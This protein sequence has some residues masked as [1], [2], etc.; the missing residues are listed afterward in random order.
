VR[1]EPN[2]GPVTSLFGEPSRAAIL[3]VLW[4]GRAL[5]ASEL[6]RIAGLSPTAASGH[7]SKL[8]N[9]KL[10]IMERQGRHRYYRLASAAVAEIIENLAQLTERP[11][12]LG[13]PKLSPAARSLRYAR[14]CYNHLAGELA[15]EVAQALENRGYLRREDDKRYELGGEEARR[16]F[17]AQGIDFQALRP[18]RYGLA[19]QC[20]DWT[21]RCPHL[22]GPLGTRLFQCWC[23]RGWLKHREEQ[24]RLINVT[25]LGRSQLRQQLGI[26]EWIP[27]VSEKPN[28]QSK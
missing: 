4:D 28:E 10:L 5:P 13:A 6:A 14:S 20:L 15:V 1:I 8:V 19:K 23:E 18:G 3:T 12:P 11:V 21:E 24:P 22:G 17:V 2:I 9:G 7:L 27:S 25:G 26:A 16:W